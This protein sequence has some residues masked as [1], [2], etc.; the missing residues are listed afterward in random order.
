MADKG[1]VDK[2]FAHHPLPIK[3]I[4]AIYA[5]YIYCVSVSALV[6]YALKPQTAELLSY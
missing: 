6:S 2:T 3:H 4:Y 1:S 5:K